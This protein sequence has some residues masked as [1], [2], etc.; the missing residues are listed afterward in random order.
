M[1]SLSIKLFLSDAASGHDN[2]EWK[3]Q[4]LQSP[5]YYILF[6]ADGRSSSFWTTKQ[7]EG[8]SDG[9]YSHWNYPWITDLFYG[10]LVWD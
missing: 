6:F 3:L 7:Q 9:K 5:Y 4:F 10:S 8:V 1:Y 2:R